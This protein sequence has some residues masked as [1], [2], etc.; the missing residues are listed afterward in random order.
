MTAKWKKGYGPSCPFCG[1]VRS[2]RIKSGWS[3]PNDNYL[4]H[5]R[6]EECR[7]TFVTVE[8]LVEPGET[9]FNRLNYYGRE[10]R[11]AAYRRREA[12]TDMTRPDL[13]VK[14]D[15]VF[16][17]VIVR[18]ARPLDKSRCMRGHKLTDDNVYI[19]PSSG[20]RRCRTCR[21]A[22]QASRY[23]DSKDKGG[24]PIQ[25]DDPRHVADRERQRRKRA[26]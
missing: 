20:Y 18:R 13:I 23:A 22:Y 17:K 6:C 16:V 8:A 1:S 10:L 26:A 14:S 19:G 9:T 7:E 15:L 24:R 25:F 2:T 11:R 5:K 4:R 21:D 12:K 3:E